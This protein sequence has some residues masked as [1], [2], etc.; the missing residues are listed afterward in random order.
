MHSQNADKLP[1]KNLL[2]LQIDL[3]GYVTTNS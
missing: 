2:S 3:K 1:K